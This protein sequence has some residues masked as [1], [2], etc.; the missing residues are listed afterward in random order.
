MAEVSTETTAPHINELRVLM[1][2]QLRAL[3]Q[4]APGDA[5]DSE[6]KRSKGVSELAGV[7]VATARVEVD[8]LAV[9]EGDGDLPFLTAPALDKKPPPQLHDALV[10]GPA[11]DHPW[12]T[13]RVVHKL[14]G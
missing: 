8:Y 10:R 3:R 4:A 7:M 5:L 14:K 1:M 6:I 11:D 9:I 12:K 2:A 13:G